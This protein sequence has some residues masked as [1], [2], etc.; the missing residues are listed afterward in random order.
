MCAKPQ[1]EQDI[2]SPEAV[3]VERE[4]LPPPPLP[5]LAPVS[6]HNRV[7]VQ[8]AMMTASMAALLCWVFVLGFVIW[9]PAAGFIAVYLY[10][11]RTGQSLTT[12]AGARMGWLTGTF[13]FGITALLFTISVI[14]FANS[15]SALAALQ[16]QM[17]SM[18]WG[19]PT[20]AAQA[21]KMLQNPTTLIVGMLCFLPF[22]FA[23]I[24]SFCAAGGALG[25]K[26]LARD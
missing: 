2:P 4:P 26:I 1:R 14:A 5:T 13:L 25:A 16:Q 17:R 18:P 24:M 19:D 23:V 7:A 11:R 22:L 8:I 15:E 3:V 21:V 6:F 9:L 20:S 12:G 10:R